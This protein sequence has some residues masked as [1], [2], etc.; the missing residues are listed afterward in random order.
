MRGHELLTTQELA[1]VRRRSDLM[2]LALVAHAW[3]IIAAAMA[4]FAAWPNPFT[5]IL[6]VLLIGSRQLGLAILMH[7][8]AHG[9]LARTHWLNEFLGSWATGDAVAADLHAY[10]PYHLKHH[11]YTQQTEDP[12]LVLSAPFPITRSSL[13]R[14]LLRDLSGQTG[15]KQRR[16]QIRAALGK[17]EWPLAQHLRHF[18]AKL[19]RPLIV[20]T[21]LFALLAGAGYWW[22]YP[23]LWLVPLFTW[24]MAVTRVRNIAEHAL[25]PD[26]DD[27]FRNA[28]TTY[29]SPLVALFLAPY[30]VNYHIDHHLLMW[31]PC[32]N[33]PKLHRLLAAKGLRPKMEVQ[34]SYWRVLRLA[35]SKP[36]T[37]SAERVG[38]RNSV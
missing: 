25:V 17:P 36:L 37:A 5:Y 12:D 29:A 19:G 7:D 11:R 35:A 21:L 24:Y 18:A 15:L 13:A 1:E 14:K 9:A 22:L 27:P 16:V 30:W 4:L 38:A 28:R 2:G 6:A 23:A 32:F 20:N 26:N 10:R 3:A 8:S 34:P 33:L 31:V